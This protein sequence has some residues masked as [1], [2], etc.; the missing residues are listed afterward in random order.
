MKHYSCRLC[1]G[2]A[3]F[4]DHDAVWLAELLQYRLDDMGQKG[5]TINVKFSRASVEVLIPRLLEQYMAPKIARLPKE[6]E[7]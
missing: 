1:E 3:G 7:S 5:K 2:T 4:H 6:S